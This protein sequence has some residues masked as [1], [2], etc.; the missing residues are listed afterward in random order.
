[1]SVFVDTSALYAILDADD[2]NHERAG[3]LWRDLV[4]QE[5]QLVSSNYVLL[6]TLSLV[7]HRLGM[8]AVRSLQEQGIPLLH[9][10]YGYLPQKLD[11]VVL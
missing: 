11:S 2:E 1:M 9:G 7:Q 3:R 8:R 6:E 4:A 10:N 5:T